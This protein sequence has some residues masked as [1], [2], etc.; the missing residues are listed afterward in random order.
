MV[1]N[2]LFH[3][4]LPLAAGRLRL[5]R[6]LQPPEV[7]IPGGRGMV[8][9]GNVGDK[10]NE[11]WRYVDPSQSAAASMGYWLVAFPHELVRSEG[12]PRIKVLACLVARSRVWRRGGAY[13][14]DPIAFSA[15]QGT[16]NRHAA[17]MSRMAP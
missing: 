15:V 16:V 12:T 8:S 10:W 7:P 5:D 4:G 9:P 6:L 14:F 17:K 11:A 1:T 13:H 3:A 2:L